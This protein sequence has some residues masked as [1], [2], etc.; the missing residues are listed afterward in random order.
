MKNIFQIKYVT[1]IV[2]MMLIISFCLA[3]CSS[4]DS[5]D[6][7]N[8]TETSYTSDFLRIAVDEPDTAD[9][10]CTDGNYDIPLNV[11]DCLIEIKAKKDGTSSFVPSLADS[12]K[13]SDD[14]LVYTFHLHKGVKFSNGSPLT[15]D[16]KNT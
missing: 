13:V 11:F 15:I 6:D 9:P 12:W 1:G 7:E 3:G 2:L 10:Q 16:C 14:G 5:S 4:D 8:K